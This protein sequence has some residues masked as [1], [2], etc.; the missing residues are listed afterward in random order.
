L[1]GETW[2]SIL[3]DAR[4][5]AFENGGVHDN[6]WANHQLNGFP[7]AMPNNWLQR[8]ELCAAAAPER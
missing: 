3:D 8:M 5:A 6:L 4:E 1:S 2:L 7:T